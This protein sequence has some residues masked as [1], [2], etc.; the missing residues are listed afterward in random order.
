MS[1]D[2]VYEALSGD[3]D[4]RWAFG[5]GFADPLAGVD[6]TVPPDVDPADLAAYCLM[7]GDDTLVMSH[8]LQEWCTNAPDLEEEVALANIGLDLLGQTRMLYA[9]AGHA[10]GTG[11]GEDAY[12]YFRDPEEFANV[13][14][15]ETPRG[16]FGDLI[17]KLL[18]FATWRL[19]LLQRLIPSRDPVLAAIAAKGVK[20]VAYHRDH[21][22]QWAVRLGDGT[23]ESHRRM[24]AGLDRLWPLVGELFTPHEVE[25]RLARAGVAADP[26]ALR[27]EFDAVLDQVL[28]AATLRRP[29]A[30]PEPGGRRGAH[31]EAL[32][33]LLAELQSVARAFPEA[34]W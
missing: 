31:T 23:D 10:D 13:R 14:L 17:A 11:R 12:A 1:F 20:E 2:N 3:G 9:R 32:A 33:P 6:T 26:A 28:T 29:E 15:A 8:R 4:A 27:A 19:A 22:A 30:P 16:D 25:E 18:V 5:T 21:A 7:L 34:T 24:Q